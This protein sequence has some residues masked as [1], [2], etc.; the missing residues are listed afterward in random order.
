[1]SWYAKP[2]GA[3]EIDSNEAKNNMLEIASVLQNYN[4]TKESQ[5]AIIGN[6]YGESGLNPWRWEGDE[7][8]EYGGYG[9]YQYT[10][11]TTYLNGATAIQ[12]YSPNL[13]TSNQTTGAT[14]L[15]GK[16]QTIVIAENTIG[17]W[18]PYCWRDYWDRNEYPE[19]YALHQNILN[20]YGDGDFL[21]LDD[22]KKISDLY[23][24]T[25]AFLSCY[26]G[27]LYPNM[28]ARYNYA[29][30][31]YS[32]ITGGTPIP[33]T[34]TPTPTPTKRKMPLWFYLRPYF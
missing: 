25:F 10:P 3:Y 26:E 34:P 31:A 16:A 7:V 33:P 19:L 17:K 13:S 18:Y 2:S 4:F 27:P 9:L 5:A 12:G 30:T 29:Q 11:S 32:V 24:A 14:P 8:D 28:T 20:T 6:A 15:D 22:F 23:Q 1:M 21:Y